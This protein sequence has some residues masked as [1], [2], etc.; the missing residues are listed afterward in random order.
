[1]AFNFSQFRQDYDLKKIGIAL[2]L[3]LS[4]VGGIVAGLMLVQGRIDIRNRA[5]D[6][7]PVGEV[8]LV[9][10]KFT[11]TTSA[12]TFTYEVSVTSS[13]LDGTNSTLSP[14]TI[15]NPPVTTDTTGTSTVVT[16]DVANVPYLGQYRC[17]IK[18]SATATNSCG[19]KTATAEQFGSLVCRPDENTPGDPVTTP[20]TDG[21]G[22]NDPICQDCSKVEV[23]L[24]FDQP[25]G[26]QQPTLTPPNVYND[27]LKI[28][29]LTIEFKGECGATM[30][31]E[32]VKKIEFRAYDNES[33]SGEP[34]VTPIPLNTDDS[35]DNYDR[36][37]SSIK[38]DEALIKAG[39]PYNEGSR[40]RLHQANGDKCR[41][42]KVNVE[43]VDDPE[44]R[45]ICPNTPQENI[46][47][48]STCVP[49]EIIDNP[50][51]PN[52]GCPGDPDG[53][54]PNDTPKCYFEPQN[55]CPRRNAETHFK[56]YTG[57]SGG[58]L[59]Y[60]D[61]F[62]GD[63]SG[64]DQ[65]VGITDGE[66]HFYNYPDGGSYDVRLRCDNGQKCVKRVRVTCTDGPGGPGPGDPGNPGN[67]GEPDEPNACV[68]PAISGIC[69]DQPAQ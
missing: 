69:T 55:S 62:R 2:V 13:A 7:C 20:P 37:G 23:K 44:G 48:S 33:C 60:D 8:K 42:Y 63:A 54:R 58:N 21:G 36:Y 9:K 27:D 6:S 47:C 16:A 1:M 66:D 10:C 30:S 45:P 41:C 68:L 61:D 5:A 52:D 53:P 31:C 38:C 34:N 11:V 57:G 4:I 43:F 29:R 50:N 12:P 18:V 64:N 59:G 40:F 14:V 28:G 22:G 26:Q 25:N 19:S 32:K 3:L 39:E 35:D 51:D 67:P 17:D 15:V 65:R 49:P 24:N 56:S 46:C